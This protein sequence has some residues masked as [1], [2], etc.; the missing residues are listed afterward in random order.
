MDTEVRLFDTTTD[1]DKYEA[2]DAAEANVFLKGKGT[3]VRLPI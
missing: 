2:N 3:I 1:G